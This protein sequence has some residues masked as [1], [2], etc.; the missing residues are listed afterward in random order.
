MIGPLFLYTRIF[1]RSQ[2]ASRARAWERL[3]TSAKVL[4]KKV[5][6]AVD[7][8][9]AEVMS[10]GMEVILKCAA[11]WRADLESVKQQGAKALRHS[12]E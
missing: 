6:H 3:E 7:A 5:G 4:G 12:S 2:V 10:K 8:K 1:P 9:C 11:G